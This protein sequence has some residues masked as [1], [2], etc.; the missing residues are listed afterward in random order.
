MKK[1]INRFSIPAQWLPH[2]TRIGLGLVVVFIFV[3]H[4]N[5]VLNLP[6]V[7]TFEGVLYDARVRATMPGS[8]NPQVVIIDI[9]EK[10]LKEEGR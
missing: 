7:D 5:H 10:S 3:L 2:A 9:D 8:I 6:L 1:L 4:G